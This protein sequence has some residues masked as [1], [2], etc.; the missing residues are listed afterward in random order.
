MVVSFIG[1]G[2]QSTRR[3]PPTCRK[4]LTNFITECIDQICGEMESIDRYNDV[5]GKFLAFDRCLD[6]LTLQVVI[7]VCKPMSVLLWLEQNNLE[8]S[9]TQGHSNFDFNWVIGF[10]EVWNMEK[11]KK[12]N[13]TDATDNHRVRT[14]ARWATKK[15]RKNPMG[16]ELMT[17]D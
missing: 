14:I 16:N 9:T 13:I 3:K 2:N 7:S 17:F 1:G 4:S 10:R 8:L 11:R 12:G 15:R 6:N 5:I